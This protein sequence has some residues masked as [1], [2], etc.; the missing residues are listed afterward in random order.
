MADNDN[1]VRFRRPEKKPA[2][3]APRS[4]GGGSPQKPPGSWLSWAAWGAIVGV[5]LLLVVLQQ[6][7]VLGF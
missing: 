6:T 4:D 5:S 3:P 7:G 2:K 1:V